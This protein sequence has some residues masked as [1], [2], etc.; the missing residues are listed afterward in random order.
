MVDVPQDYENTL[1]VS[2]S[3]NL[4]FSNSQFTIPVGEAE[5]KSHQNC[6]KS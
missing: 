5:A 1:R 3:A 6:E 4:S 2:A